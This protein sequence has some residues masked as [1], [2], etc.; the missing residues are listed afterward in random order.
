MT[1]LRTLITDLSGGVTCQFAEV[2]ADMTRQFGEVRAN[3]KGAD[4]EVDRLFLY[5]D[6]KTEHLSTESG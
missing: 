5:L 2:R 1:D 4:D 3:V 6:Q